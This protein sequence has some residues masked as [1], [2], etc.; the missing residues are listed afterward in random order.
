[1]LCCWRKAKARTKS[2]CVICM[3]ETKKAVNHPCKVC[4]KNAWHICKE[5]N[6]QLIN[7]PICRASFN[8]HNTISNPINIVIENNNLN[9]TIQIN[10]ESRRLRIHANRCLTININI[11][12]RFNCFKQVYQYCHKFM[13][14]ILKLLIFLTSVIYIGKVLVFM[15]CKFDCIGMDEKD[16][17]YCYNIVKPAKFWHVFDH[18][19]ASFVTGWMFWL[20]A[21]LCIGNYNRDRRRRY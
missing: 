18:F 8:R 12:N 10:N 7:C 16:E 6:K 15:Y 3:D 19:P 2:A 20:V 11:V 13:L 21:I 14:S 4:R 5:C 1:M 17:C 9:A